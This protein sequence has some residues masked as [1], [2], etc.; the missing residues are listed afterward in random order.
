VWH[1]PYR[2]LTAKRTSVITNGNM[3]TQC[4]M[5][6]M[7]RACNISC[8]KSCPFKEENYSFFFINFTA[9]I[10]RMHTEFEDLLLLPCMSIQHLHS[11]LTTTSLSIIQTTSQF[12]ARRV[13]EVCTSFHYITN[14]PSSDL[15]QYNYCLGLLRPCRWD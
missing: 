6:M 13:Q 15:M 2:K 14:D 9:H 4:S 5:S 7:T 12:H 10:S 1:I 8:Q 11:P 3:I